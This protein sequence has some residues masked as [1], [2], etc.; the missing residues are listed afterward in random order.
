MCPGQCPPSTWT[1]AHAQCSFLAAISH[2]AS[3]DT[4]T[5]RAREA[6]VA[7]RVTFSVANGT[8]YS[9]TAVRSGR[10]LRLS[11]RHRRSGRRR[12]A[13][14]DNAR[15]GRHPAHR[16]TVLE[17]QGRREPQPR[18]PRLLFRGDDAVRAPLARAP[19][20]GAGRAGGRG[21][22][23]RRRRRT[24]RILE[25]PARHRDSVQPDLAD[26]GGSPLSHGF[27][28]IISG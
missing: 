1:L 3:I 19:R 14:K 2:Q 8:D 5:R 6:G 26:L 9:G 21:T 13:R 25:F 18:R 24:G 17:R 22:A 4:A 23:P 15:E 16:R 12:Q 7:D 10:A 28:A 20:T 11:A 27:N